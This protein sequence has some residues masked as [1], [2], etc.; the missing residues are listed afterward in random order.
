[1]LFASIFIPPRLSLFSFMGTEKTSEDRWYVLR[2]LARPNAKKPAYK[3]L[4]EMPEMAGCVL[5]PLKQHVFKEFGSVL[6]VSSPK[7]PTLSSSISRRKSWS[8]N[9]Q[10]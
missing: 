5:E 7:C 3:Q 2:D 4:Q 1:M 10:L 8:L 9:P 6:C